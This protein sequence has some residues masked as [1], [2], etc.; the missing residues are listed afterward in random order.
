MKAG[1]S[2]RLP[3]LR[4]PPSGHPAGGSDLRA[5]PS[6]RATLRLARRVLARRAEAAERTARAKP[7]LGTRPALP[8]SVRARQLEARRPAPT[9]GRRSCDLVRQSQKRHLAAHPRTGRAGSRGSPRPLLQLR[10]GARRRSQGACGSSLLSCRRIGPSRLRRS[11][12]GDRRANARSSRDALLR[13]AA[14]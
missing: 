3:C 11:S 6:R 8:P 1:R 2:T 10:R 14:A 13:V 7:W 4:L 12:A 5:R 9:S